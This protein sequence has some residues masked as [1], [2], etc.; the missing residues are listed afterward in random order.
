[1]ETWP[2]RMPEPGSVAHILY[3]LNHNTANG[4]QGGN[5]TGIWFSP[6]LEKEWEGGEMA[7]S[8]VVFFVI[9]VW[10]RWVV[11]RWLQ[12]IPCCNCM[13]PCESRPYVQTIQP[14]GRFQRIATQKTLYCW[15]RAKGKRACSRP[16]PGWR[17]RCRGDYRFWKQ[18]WTLR[19][20]LL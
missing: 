15:S 9:R 16:R 5:L 8:I 19:Q 1:M 7:L 12:A 3:E 4:Q 13:C 10:L 18:R 14:T 17:N 2:S 11:V 6:E 20:R